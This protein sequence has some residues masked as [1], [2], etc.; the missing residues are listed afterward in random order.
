MSIKKIAVITDAIG[1][2][3]LMEALARKEIEVVFIGNSESV[4]HKVRQQTDIILDEKIRKW[5]ITK[6]EKKVILSR[7]HYQIG[8]NN[9]DGIDMIIESISGSYYEKKERI[10]RLEKCLDEDVIIAT[11][12][13]AYRVSDFQKDLKHPEKL[14]GIHFIRHGAEIVRGNK[15]SD[16]TYLTL[17]KFTEQLN[18]CSIDVKDSPGNVFNRLTLC[19]INEAVDILSEGIVSP[20]DLDT[21]LKSVFEW[22]RGPLEMADRI[23]LDQILDELDM[24]YRVTRNKKYLASTYLRNLVADGRTG[25]VSGK[26]FFQY[27]LEGN[28]IHETQ[29]VF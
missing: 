24:L 14:I 3:W 8:I 4:I 23:G 28:R 19:F 29:E 26:G 12:A 25:T 20:K 13:L 16:D 18:I 22:R 7:I 27:D 9:L 21:M 5:S 2:C 17:Q 6:A 15:T 11:K 1:D 10:E